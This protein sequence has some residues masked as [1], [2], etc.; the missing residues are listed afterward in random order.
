LP[1][2]QVRD[3]AHEPEHLPHLLGR[4]AIDVVDEDDDL[5]D[6]TRHLFADVVLHVRRRSGFSRF[7]GAARPSLDHG[8]GTVRDSGSD[9]IDPG[10]RRDVGERLER[11]ESSERLAVEG[12][13]LSQGASQLRKE[14]PVEIA[15][16][17]EPHGLKRSTSTFISSSE[18]SGR[19]VMCSYMKFK[20]V[21][22]PLPH[23]PLIPTTKPAAG[24]PDSTPSASC[25]ANGA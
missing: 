9:R 6:V 10:N 15:A 11:V 20:N 16:P 3:R 12:R 14:L 13:T 19:E 23:A 25:R 4:E 18:A 21:D 8:E 24:L 17:R 2:P 1:P 22:F 5:A 7:L